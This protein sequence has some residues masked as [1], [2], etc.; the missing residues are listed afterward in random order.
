MKWSLQ[1]LNK[2]VNQD[3]EF[4]VS[5]DFSEEIKNISDILGITETKVKGSIHVID[6][7]KFRFNLHIKTTLILEDARTLDPVDFEVDLDTEEKFSKEEEQD[8]EVIV[9]EA[10]TIELKPL[11]WEIVL[12]EKPIRYVRADD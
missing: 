1:Q 6:F 7:N 4:E 12:I 9:I 3:Y 10:N 5:Y 11:I 2:L 8:E